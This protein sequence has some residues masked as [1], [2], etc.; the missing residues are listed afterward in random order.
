MTATSSEVGAR[1]SAA[2]SLANSSSMA[3]GLVT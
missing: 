2:R 3:K 1:R